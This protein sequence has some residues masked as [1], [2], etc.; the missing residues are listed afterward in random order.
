MSFVHADPEFS[1]IIDA[2]AAEGPIASAAMI[3]KDYWICHSL[4]ALS[5]SGLQFWFKGGTSLSKAFNLIERFSE[6]IDLVV[7]PGTIANLPPVSSWKR[8]APGPNRARRE[9]WDALLPAL[10]VPG[11][12]VVLDHQHDETFRNPAYRV[13]YPGRFVGALSSE[14]S[15]L[16]PYV[17]LETSYG[18]NARSAVAPSV[19]RPVTSAVHEWLAARGQ[20][21]EFTDNR[22]HAVE[23]VHPYVTLI[24]KLDAITR[25]Y[26]RAAD[27]FEAASFARHY[28]DAAR[29]IRAEASLPG[30]E[31]SVAELTRTMYAEHQIR[32][33]VSPD[34]EAFVLPEEVRSQRIQAGYAAIG[35][36]FWGTRMTLAEAC[37]TIIEW[38]RRNPMPEAD[39]PDAR[40]IPLQDE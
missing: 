32:K 8:E 31:C 27:R 37:E 13:R 5:R 2:V 29:I 24:E 9:F 36:M 21:Q 10:Q 23:C 16:R 1:D 22:A 6:D 38:L 33:L 12:E 20:L 3:E 39:E 17:F 11:A 7:L 35:G 19:S 14:D 40:S 26:H 28:E 30:I 15:V 18:N 4:W 25:R 34:D